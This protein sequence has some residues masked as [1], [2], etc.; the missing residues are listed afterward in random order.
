MR[1]F[2]PIS[3]VQPSNSNWGG[4]YWAAKIA[5]NSSTHSAVTST[6]GMGRIEMTSASGEKLTYAVK[7][8][9]SANDG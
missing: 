7:F 6:N 8:A 4:A 5:T 2:I 3:G 9:Q 1:H